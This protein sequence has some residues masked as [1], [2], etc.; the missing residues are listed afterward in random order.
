M[1]LIW[2]PRLYLAQISLGIGIAFWVLACMTA[3]RERALP[4]AAYAST[5]L[6][7]LFISYSV[8][9]RVPAQQGT[10]QQ[11]TAQQGTAQQTTAPWSSCDTWNPEVRLPLIDGRVSALFCYR[12][13]LIRANSGQGSNIDHDRLLTNYREAIEYLPRALQ[14]GLLAPFPVDWFK[15][16]TSPGSQIKRMVSG[17][18]MATVYVLW[19]GIIWA[20]KQR[21]VRLTS[22]ALLIFGVAGVLF[23]AY[24]SPNVGTIYRMRF[25]F[26]VMLI[27]LGSAGWAY[28]L[29][30][31][32][33]D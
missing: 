33:R 9:Q 22:I 8:A 17:L 2:W 5:L 6:L 19:I 23:Y 12:H 3:L 24:S 29:R 7:A 11:G 20:F 26:T 10:A 32:V 4:R 13:G 25:P 16:G 28:R 14:V 27:C 1:W 18:E 15:A 21:R 30:S 31:C